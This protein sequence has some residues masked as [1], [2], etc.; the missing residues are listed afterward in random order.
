M[1]YAIFIYGSKPSV[2]VI[3][4]QENEKFRYR[5]G[6][7]WHEA[8]IST[9]YSMAVPLEYFTSFVRRSG[10]SRP[11]IHYLEDMHVAPR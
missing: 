11:A 5:S 6:Y 7:G 3:M 2:S 4:E 8:P 1:L 9:D 10:N